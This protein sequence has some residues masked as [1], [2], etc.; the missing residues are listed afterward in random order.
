MRAI[1]I[2]EFG[3]PKDLKLDEIPR[4]EAGPGEILVRV[5]SAALNFPDILK[6]AGKH[7]NKIEPPFSPGSEFAGTVAEVGAGIE[8][9]EEGDRVFA[10]MGSGG[11]A[12]YVAVPVDKIV[13]TPDG[14][15]DEDAA[16]F[17]LVYH[18]SYI[19]LI[20]RGRLQP[21]E[22]VL[23]HSAAGGVGLAAVQIARAKGAGKIIGTVGSDEKEELVRENG[24]DLVVNYQTQDFVEVVKRETD[25]R[26]ADIIYDPLGGEVGERSAKCIASEGRIL[27]IGFTSGAF[28]K[29]R[30]NHMLVKNYDVIG[31]LIGRTNEAAHRRS[32]DEVLD[33]YLKGAIKPVI[34]RRFPME[35]AAEAMELLSSRK[36]VGKIVLNW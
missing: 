13:R 9:F 30:S 19:A 11:F 24:A 28:P 5:R 22:T 6:I 20:H 4:P 33:L 15:P 36:A 12:E 23:I 14:M 18:T 1:R 25:G 8:G 26:G 2:H 7:Q 16:V 21:G 17:S 27:I 32:W 31:V 3:E 10:R 34:S 29:F 35:K